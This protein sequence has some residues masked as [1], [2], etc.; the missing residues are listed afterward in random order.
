MTPE[1]LIQSICN[2]LFSWENNETSNETVYFNNNN[3]FITYSA[4]VTL[5]DVHR[6]ITISR[7][8]QKITIS[9]KK[10]FDAF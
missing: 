2:D 10:N 7:E 5:E 9:R 1:E 4:P 6:R 8:K 3:N